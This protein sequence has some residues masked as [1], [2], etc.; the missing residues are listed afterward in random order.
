M[1]DQTMKKGTGRSIAP[2]RARVGVTIG[3]YVRPGMTKNNSVG[4]VGTTY[5]RE[6]HSQRSQR[7]DIQPSWTA[8][9]TD[10]EIVHPAAIPSQSPVEAGGLPKGRIKANA[11]RQLGDVFGG[12]G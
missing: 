8:E 4:K 10:L 6:L 5:G 3:G 1:P 2:P 11:F 12:R 9:L 7:S